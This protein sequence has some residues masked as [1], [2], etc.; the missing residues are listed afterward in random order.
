MERA[1]ASLLMV[2][3]FAACNRAPAPTKD[4][5]EPLRQYSMRGVVIRLD[6]EGHIA[7]LKNEKIEG[8]MESMTMDFPVK[9]Q[10]DFNKLHA[11]DTIRATVFVQGLEYWVGKVQPDNS[12]RGPIVPQ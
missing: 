7:T 1:F 5:N 8:W 2:T 9:D 3:V 10:T 11:G 4:S 12:P 6:P